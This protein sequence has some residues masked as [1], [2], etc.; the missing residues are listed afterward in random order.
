MVDSSG[1]FSKTM[2]VEKSGGIGQVGELIDAT[3]LQLKLNKALENADYWRLMYDKLLKHIEHEST[4]IRHLE[5]QLW[6]G[7]TF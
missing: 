4:Y 5:K 6:G 3:E 1:R 7:H 2:G